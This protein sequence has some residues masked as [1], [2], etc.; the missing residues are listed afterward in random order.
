[1]FLALL[2]LRKMN[3]RIT[4][5][6]GVGVGLL[7]LPACASKQ[8]NQLQ[9][10]VQTLESRLQRYQSETS[11]DT[12]FTTQTLQGLNQ[13]LNQAFRDIRT[14]Q[15]NMQNTLEQISTRLATVE[16]KVEMLDARVKNLEE[17]A[18]NSYADLTNS[19]QQNRTEAQQA[20]EQNV[21]EI[22]SGLQSLRGSVS[23]L[24]RQDQ[25]IQ[26]GTAREFQAI[27]GRLEK[28]LAT[29]D[30][31]T[32]KLFARIL[33]ELGGEV[34]KTPVSATPELQTSP[35]GGSEKPAGNIHV[36]Q[37]GETLS[38]I[39]AKHGVDMQ[40]LMQLN[41]INDPSKIYSGQT[42]RLP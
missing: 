18:I 5:W 8:I 39:A 41:G 24:E 38:G 1:M 35:A 21:S 13:Q 42:L 22:K 25:V 28:R 2:G 36:V 3:I 34:P 37:R 40:T 14:N 26:Q 32:R 6:M 27:E 31:E 23:T 33:K 20:L 16:Q 10:S 9:G 11:Q 4:P 7:L 19:I 17:G 12:Q 29:Q 30:E 15:T